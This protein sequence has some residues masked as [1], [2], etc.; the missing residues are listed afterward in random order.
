MKNTTIKK[1]RL[2]KNFPQKIKLFLGILVGM[3]AIYYL[4]FNDY[5]IIRHFRTKKELL[6]I[7]SKIELLKKQQE[8]IVITIEKLKTDYDYIEQLAREKLML[9]KEGEELY[10]VKKSNSGINLEKQ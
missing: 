2:P 4:S 1:R 9:V 10:I 7:K 8:E 5:G 3:A 6:Q